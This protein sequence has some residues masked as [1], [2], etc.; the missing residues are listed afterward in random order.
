MPIGGRKRS[1]S[2]PSSGDWGARSGE[3]TAHATNKPTMTSGTSGGQR[4]SRVLV[5]TS[6]SASCGPAVTTSTAIYLSIYLSLSGVPNL[7]IDVGVQHVDE[8]V[9]A[10]I[11]NAQDHDH[12]LD[13]R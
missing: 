11:H 13:K 1:V 9:R 12:P 5:E 3:N 7:R 8:K 6:R 2:V 4:R 10:D